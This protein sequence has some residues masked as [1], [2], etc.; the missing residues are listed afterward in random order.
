MTLSTF[1]KSL[2]APFVN[3]RWSWG[4]VRPEDGVLFLR[5]WED[6]VQRIDGAQWVRVA[7]N[8]QYAGSS[9]DGWLERVK[10]LDSIRGGSKCFLVFVFAKD[11]A[12]VPRDVKSFLDDAVIEGTEIAEFD[13]DTRIRLGRRIPAQE[14]MPAAV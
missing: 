8:A 7:A 12:A 13:G 10:H 1:F 11:K 3:A 14:L 6:E 2:G 5:V 9:D 4:A